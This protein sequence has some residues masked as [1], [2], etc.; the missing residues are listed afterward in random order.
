MVL[1]R[2]PISLTKRVGFYGLF[3]RKQSMKSSWKNWAIKIAT[4]VVVLALAIFV[5]LIL[6]FNWVAIA[7]LSTTA[8]VIWAV[9]HQGI[10][11][12]L[13]RP[14]LEI[15]LFESESP[16]LRQVTGRDPKTGKPVCV[17]YPLSIQLKNT[18]KT[19]AKNTQPLVTG[20]G[21]IID[22]KW[23]TQD[24]WISAPIHWG[25]D[26]PSEVGAEKPTEERDLVPHRPYVFNFGTMRTDYPDLFILN[27][28]IMPGN[29]K[30]DYPPGEFCFELTVF[31]EGAD[32][33]K[34]YFHIE[35]D[36]GCTDKFD[37]VKEKIRIYLKDHPPW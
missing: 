11:A 12:W 14:R 22:A 16:Y 10:L 35:W 36:G 28:I 1:I 23:Q 33:V 17:I 19:L 20:M 13:D 24:N 27:T 15:S 8:A 31:A 4:A 37:E 3:G 7:A 5:I 34:K 18:G 30:R 6:K 2:N 25:L 32:P 26:V 9:F 29:Q 21:C